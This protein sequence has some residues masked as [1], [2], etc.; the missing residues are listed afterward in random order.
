MVEK[1]ADMC[2]QAQFFFVELQLPSQVIYYGVRRGSRLL[3][4]EGVYIRRG[5]N[6]SF[7]ISGYANLISSGKCKCS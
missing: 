2:A 4:E 3:W 6:E 1:E 7:M 5:G